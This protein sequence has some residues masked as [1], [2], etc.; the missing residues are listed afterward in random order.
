L[1]SAAFPYINHV[2]GFNLG[3][4]LLLASIIRLARFVIVLAAGT[5]AKLLGGK[6][7]G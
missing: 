7:V 4:E 3:R 1:F 5:L 2:H 6:L